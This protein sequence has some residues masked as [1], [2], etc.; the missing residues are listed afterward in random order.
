MRPNLTVTI[1]DL[2]RPIHGKISTGM[3]LRYDPIYDQIRHARHFEDPAL[4]Q[5]I[6]ERDL[7]KPDWEMVEA[8]C[9]EVLLNQ[10]KDLQIAGWLTEAWIALDEFDGLIHGLE[11][12]ESLC[13]KFWPDLYPPIDDNDD[14]EYRLRIL[15]WLDSCLTERILH[16]PL[17]GSD[18]QEHG[19]TLA[20]WMSANQLETTAKR[21][22]EGQKL[23]ELAESKNQPTLSQFSQSLSL[24][25]PKRL[26]DLKQGVAN[27]ITTLIHFK[28]TINQLAP[29][30]CPSYKTTLDRLDQI[31][32]LI[33]SPETSSL[34]SK[35]STTPEDT[36]PNPL[37]LP[38]SDENLPFAPPSSRRQAYIQLQQIAQYLDYIEPHSPTPHILKILVSWQDKTLADIFAEFEDSSQELSFLARFMRKK[39]TT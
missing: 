35:S 39:V 14:L 24:T 13:Q 25:D 7:K 21:S 16:I 29:N 19:F 5:G 31:T 3:W 32:R 10:S 11:L 18:I 1:P 8:L 2:T 33:G 36:S 30:Q 6:W 15:E 12:L 38:P 37:S 27:S 34:M 9:C 4:S 22:P 28:K 20:D 17:T 23:I 26:E